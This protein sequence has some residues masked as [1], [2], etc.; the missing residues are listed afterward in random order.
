MFNLLEILQDKYDAKTLSLIFFKN[1]AATSLHVKLLYNART[2]K[3]DIISK[4]LQ[5]QYISRETIPLRGGG[6]GMYQI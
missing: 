2:E 6:E 3:V 5:K 4:G 1:K